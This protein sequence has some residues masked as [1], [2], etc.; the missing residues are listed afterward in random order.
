[1][2]FDLDTGRI[3]IEVNFVEKQNTFKAKIYEAVADQLNRLLFRKRGAMIRDLR[4]LIPGWVSSQ[5]EMIS[6]DSDVGVGSLAAELGLVYGTGI[7]A[8]NAIVVAA[9]NSFA[10]D[11]TKVDAKTLR[12]GVNAK[13]MPATF[14]SL[15]N[16][17]EGIVRTEKGDDLHWL[18]WLLLDGFQVI[19][20]G[21]SFRFKK[22]GRSGGGYM[23]TGGIWRVPPEYA[24]TKDDNFIT[25]ALTGPLNEQ[26]IAEVFKRHIK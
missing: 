10:L 12:G 20:T 26:Q 9:T 22:A 18:K 21:Y 8:V 5:P 25:R 13:F 3:M 17:P 15:L 11:I 7:E 14:A 23:G 19:V 24:G 6:L 16:L 1:M 2:F 4:N